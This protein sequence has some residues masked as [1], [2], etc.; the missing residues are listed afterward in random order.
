MVMS[1][2]KISFSMKR[3]NYR[4]GGATQD[5]YIAFNIVAERI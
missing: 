2:L 4:M 3:P 5:A 1:P